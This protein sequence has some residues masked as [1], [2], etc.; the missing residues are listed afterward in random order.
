MEWPETVVNS[1]SRSGLFS[2]V[3]WRVFF[4]HSRSFAEGLRVADVESA[5]LTVCV[6]P[7]SCSGMSRGIPAPAVRSSARASYHKFILCERCV[8]DKAWTALPKMQRPGQNPGRRRNRVESS[9][10]L[11]GLWGSHHLAM[12]GARDERI[13][14]DFA[15][16]RI[17]DVYAVDLQRSAEGPLVVGLGFNEIGQRAQFVA[18]RVNQ[19]AL[20]Q[21]YLIHRG[22]AEL[23]LLLFGIEGLLLQFARF[24]RR[25]HARPVLLQGNIGSAHIEQRQIPEL[26]HLRLELSPRQDGAL[27]VRLGL[28]V[29]DRHRHAQLY[30]IVGELA[31][32]YLTHRIGKASRG[33]ADHMQCGYGQEVAE[34]LF[35][36]RIDYGRSSG[37]HGWAEDV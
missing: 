32:K 3:G 15:R 16:F 13:A 19:V 9:S 24:C 25:L 14:F 29:A 35:A 28:S 21:D 27:I 8:R 12:Q 37:R 11:V 5:G 6:T 36:G 17:G 1:G 26:L 23:I 30:G 20:R 7:F 18:L 10:E 33:C 31:V 34:N 22:C 4:S 2:S